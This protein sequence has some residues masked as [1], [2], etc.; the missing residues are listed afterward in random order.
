MTAIR[1][2]LSDAIADGGTTLRDFLNSDGKPG[3]FK[4]QLFVYDRKGEAC[5]ICGTPVRH[6]VLGQRATY[7][8]PACQ[9]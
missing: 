5:R 6:A 1:E 3:Y 9:K 2:V 4:Q 7:W 8:C